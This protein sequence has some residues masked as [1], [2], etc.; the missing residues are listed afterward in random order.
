[1]SLAQV[2]L[3]IAADLLDEA[4]GVVDGAFGRLA[5][6]GGADANQTLAYDLAHAASAVATGR[7]SLA[8]GERGE[9][10]ARLVV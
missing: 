8:Y 4:Q 9:V 10:E 1:M 2:D 3:K 7:A 6:L 5:A